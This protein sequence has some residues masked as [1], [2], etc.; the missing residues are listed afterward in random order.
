MAMYLSPPLGMLPRCVWVKAVGAISS[1][2]VLGLIFRPWI[3]IQ[4]D[5]PAVLQRC[6]HAPAGFTASGLAAGLEAIDQRLAI[7]TVERVVVNLDKI[8]VR[9]GTSLFR[10]AMPA[11]CAIASSPRYAPNSS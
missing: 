6:I 4:R 8:G 9:H 10:F 2:P 1:E 7:G 3:C 11:Q 5:V